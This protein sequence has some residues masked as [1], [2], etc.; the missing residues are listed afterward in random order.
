MEIAEAEVRIVEKVTLPPRI[1]NRELFRD[2]II[3][4]KAFAHCTCPDAPKYH[5]NCQ[6]HLMPILDQIETLWKNK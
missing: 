6:R 2:L 3:R 1:E 5:S 4:A